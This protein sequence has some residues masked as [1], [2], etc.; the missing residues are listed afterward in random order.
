MLP[1]QLN[2]DQIENGVKDHIDH[3][4]DGTCFVWYK[5][6]LTSEQCNSDKATLQSQKDS[7]TASLTAEVATETALITEQLAQYPV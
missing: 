6:T 3:N 7:L 2:A 1:G 5:I 4:D